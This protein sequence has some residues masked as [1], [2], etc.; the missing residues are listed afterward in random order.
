MFTR[1]VILSISSLLAFGAM[2]VA[3]GGD[4]DGAAEPVDAA[5][6]E[7]TVFVED[8]GDNDTSATGQGTATLTLDNGETYEFE[9]LCVLEPQ[10][11][12]GSEVLFSVTSYDDPSLD[13][14]QFGDDAP[15]TGLASV[16]VYDATTFDS[17]WAASS[18]YESFGGSLELSL[19]G[20]V[21]SG[22]GTF[23]AGDDPIASPEG[24]V[25]E[26]VANC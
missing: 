25:G 12:G 8:A 19:Q 21:I 9:V 18:L 16:T 23:F 3:C 11:A 1:K 24:V 7:S 26:F 6:S 10:I 4:D 15:V 5:P 20:S 14:T 17:L 22:T 13:I 2:V